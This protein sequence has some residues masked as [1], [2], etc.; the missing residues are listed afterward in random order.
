MKLLHVIYKNYINHS[1]IEGIKNKSVKSS[2]KI[3]II[4]VDIKSP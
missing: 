1:D 3:V 2:A 4:T